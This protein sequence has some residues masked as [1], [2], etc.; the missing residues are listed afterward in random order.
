[1]KTVLKVILFAAL[2]TLLLTLASCKTRIS[3]RY[4]PDL[5]SYEAADI[6]AGTFDFQKDGEVTYHASPQ[7]AFHGKYTVLENT[8]TF[9]FEEEG[10]RY[11]GTFFFEKT[12]EYLTIG[13]YTYAKESKNDQPYG[14]S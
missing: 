6:S 2:V 7:K 9:D 11:E 1:L 8:I 14:L 4:G 13:D 12:A 3:G 5:S 10:C